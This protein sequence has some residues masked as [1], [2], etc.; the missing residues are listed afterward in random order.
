MDLVFNLELRRISKKVTPR[1][2]YKKQMKLVS[3]KKIE[4]FELV[5]LR[6]TFLGEKEKK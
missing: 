1:K 5:N 6:A 2:N 3:W 4:A